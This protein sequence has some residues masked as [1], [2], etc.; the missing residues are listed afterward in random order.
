MQSG[1]QAFTETWRTEYPPAWDTTTGPTVTRTVNGVG[2]APS[3]GGQN[4]VPWSE[5]VQYPQS[6]GADVSPYL[7]SLRKQYQEIGDTVQVPGYV[8][9]LTRPDHGEQAWGPIFLAAFVGTFAA[10]VLHRSLTSAASWFRRP[11]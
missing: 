4:S 1:V 10:M 11:R 6:P 8:V 3:I 7:S 5:P 2:Y 9:G